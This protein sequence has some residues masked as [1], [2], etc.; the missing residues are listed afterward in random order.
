MAL[1]VVGL[2]LALIAFPV[3]FFVSAALGYILCLIVI[4]FGVYMI[5]KR[6]GKTLPLVLGILLLIIGVGVFTGTLIIHMTAYTLSKTLEEVAKTKSVS[7]SLGEAI[8][9]GDWRITVTSIREGIYVK[10][11]SNYYAA[12]N[13]TK[14]VIV[15]LRIENTGKETKSLSEIW[16]FVLVTN[17]NKSYEKVY[18][19]SLE[20]VWSPSEEVMSKAISIN[21]LD[22]SKTLAPGTYT[23][24]D[25]LFLIPVDERPAKLYFKVGV[26]G[27]YEVEVKLG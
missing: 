18:P 14:I 26:I 24:G 22:T 25:M 11:D 12:K 27:P 7:A 21:I 10:S 13:D 16:S 9:L 4:G 5:A 8:A 23:E 20:W 3:A 17:T 1:F 6:G 19:I 15:K 2:L